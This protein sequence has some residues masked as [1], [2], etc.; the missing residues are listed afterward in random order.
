MLD[1]NAANGS[2]EQSKM[3]LG[4]DAGDHHASSTTDHA[5]SSFPYSVTEEMRSEH[6]FL[7]ALHDQ[8]LPEHHVTTLA[9]GVVR[10]ASSMVRKSL[11]GRRSTDVRRSTSRSGP[12]KPDADNAAPPQKSVDD[13]QSMTIRSKLQ[14]K[15]A[16]KPAEKTKQDKSPVTSLT[17]QNPWPSFRQT[18]I[19]DIMRGLHWGITPEY[20]EALE[21]SKGQLADETW[22]DVVVRTPDFTEPEALKKGKAVQVTWLGHATTLLRIPGID[23]D[24]GRSFNI[25]FDPIFSERCSPSQM[26]G[27]ARFTPAPC[28]VEDL[29]RE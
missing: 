10:R 23:R 27:P 25:L 15:V 21:R 26:A 1:T 18:G 12:P 20:R 16:G 7:D 19:I 6:P 5:S 4:S 11:D 28:K 29:P 3:N 8:P 9:A 24:S 17:F 14:E 13:P 2:P 22:D